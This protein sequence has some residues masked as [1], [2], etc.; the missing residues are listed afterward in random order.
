MTE[1][2]FWGDRQISGVYENIYLRTFVEDWFNIVKDLAKEVKG[3][4]LLDVGCGEG[5]TTKQLLNRLKIDYVCDILEPN[6]KALNFAK[7]FLSFENKIGES[8]ANSLASLKTTKKYD[9]VFTSHTNYYWASKENDFK[10]QLDKIFS[11]V[12]SD[13]KL[14]ILTLPEESD[15]Y[16]IMLKQV[17]PKFNYSSY[18]INY[19]KNKGLKVKVV[20]FKMR[21]FVGDMLDNNGN[22]YDINNFYKFIHNTSSTPSKEEA[23]QFLEKI[24]KYQKK[25]YLDFK[26][27]LIVVSK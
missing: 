27:E 23:L 12:K 4:Y 2:V 17:Y 26:D 15:H 7:T 5:H 25:G 14:M 24:K 18:I 1:W 16:N 10:N 6:E 21:M 3:K 8:F 20:R 19:Y 22:F 9:T 13:G 11:L